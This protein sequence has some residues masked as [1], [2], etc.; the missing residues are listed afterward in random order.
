MESKD[1]EGNPTTEWC[2]EYVNVPGGKT[3]LVV[4]KLKTNGYEY[5]VDTALMAEMRETLKHTATEL[6]QW[7]ENTAG[8]V[9]IQI[10]C[11][12]AG[13]SEMPRVNYSAADVIEGIVDDGETE[14]G[15]L[16]K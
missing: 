10:V 13:T 8:A 2:R 6:G 3:G 16:Q 7:Q 9:S 1:A 4:R 14:I 11:P 15:I 12:A 5:A